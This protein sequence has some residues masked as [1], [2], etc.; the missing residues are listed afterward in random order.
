MY[1]TQM[2]ERL[3]AER[4]SELGK[5]VHLTRLPKK[6]QKSGSGFGAYHL[7]R[8]GRVLGSVGVTINNGDHSNSAVSS[9]S[10]DT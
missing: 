2:I 3:V 1:N 5:E 9:T 4:Q 7:R 8:I 10:L 6:A